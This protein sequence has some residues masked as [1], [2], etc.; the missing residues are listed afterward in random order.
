MRRLIQ[1]RGSATTSAAYMYNRIPLSL[2]CGRRIEQSLRW[3]QNKHIQHTPDYGVN[4]ASA[5]RSSLLAFIR[6]PRHLYVVR[7]DTRR[8]RLLTTL[9]LTGPRVDVQIHTYG[10]E[11]HPRARTCM[12]TAD[13]FRSF[14]ITPTLPC[15]WMSQGRPTCFFEVARIACVAAIHAVF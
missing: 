2:S 3:F 10:P 8:T 9:R 5:G 13:P 11:S 15:H 4:D 12:N 14:S 1:G 7:Q 6:A